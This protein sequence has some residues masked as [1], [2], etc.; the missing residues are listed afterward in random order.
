MCKVKIFDVEGNE[1]TYSYEEYVERF[2][3]A[4]TEYGHRDYK[5]VI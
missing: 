3:K 2:P 4:T 1:I 5:V